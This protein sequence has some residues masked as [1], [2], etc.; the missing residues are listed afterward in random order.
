[1]Q[2]SMSAV[3]GWNMGWADCHGLSPGV[4]GSRTSGKKSNHAINHLYASGNRRRVTCVVSVRCLRGGFRSVPGCSCSVV[5]LL[6]SL[7]SSC[8]YPKSTEYVHA[9]VSSV[10]VR[11]YYQQPF[12]TSCNPAR[13]RCW[14]SFW[15]HFR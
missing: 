10:P 8:P 12:E 7:V 5:V 2:R 14:G 1:M 15:V 11:G 6:V 9:Y 13:L 3:L 4:P